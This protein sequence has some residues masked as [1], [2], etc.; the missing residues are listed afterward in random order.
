MGLLDLLPDLEVIDLAQPYE[1]GMPTSPTHPRFDLALRRRHGDDV[2]A[3]G[4]SGAHELLVLGGHVGTH[5]DALSH[6]S[7]D[8]RLHG[9]IPVGEALEGG[10]F[11]VH[12][13][14]AVAPLVRRGVLCDAP[15]L[16]GVDRLAPGVG[17]GVEELRSGPEPRPGDVVLV[18]T[19]WAQLWDDPAAY[20]GDD[21]GVPGLDV[22]GATW[23]AE[24]GVAAV[25]ADTIAL[26]RIPPGGGA[27]AL[28]VHALLIVEHGIN[29]IEVMAL[30]AL[31]AAGVAEF[32]FVGAPLSVVGATGAP[33][34]PVAVI[35]R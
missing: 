22:E 12:G 26:E 31:A 32:L 16:H 19:G 10:R 3:G 4:V 6:V 28:P 5:M 25:G 14:D 34:R 15:R 17:V 29:L 23:L 7:V 27:A 30:E 8:G 13:I 35:D 24:R 21:R 11:R 33:I 18:R 20:V 2:L 1:I 9:G